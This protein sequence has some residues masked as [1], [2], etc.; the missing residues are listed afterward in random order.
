LILNRIQVFLLQLLVV[1][2]LVVDDL[3]NLLLPGVLV[4]ATERMVEA[5]DVVCDPHDSIILSV[6][7]QQNFDN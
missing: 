7:I 1:L 3:G 2:L 6:F 5:L 4:R